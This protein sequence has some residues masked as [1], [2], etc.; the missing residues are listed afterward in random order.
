MAGQ[1]QELNI[2]ASSDISRPE[3]AEPSESEELSG[4][5]EI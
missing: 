2:I 5:D 3:N 4:L 1:R